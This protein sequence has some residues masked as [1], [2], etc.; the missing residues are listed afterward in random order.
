[1]L[2]STR[3]KIGTQ[4]EKIGESGSDFADLPY[5]STILSKLLKGGHTPR[6]KA[7]KLSGKS[8]PGISQNL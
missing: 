5:S 8:Y 1:M 6:L 7:T 4:H 3:T 2:I